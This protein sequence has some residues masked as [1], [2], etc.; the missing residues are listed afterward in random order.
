MS[1]SDLICDK[2]HTLCFSGHRPENLPKARNSQ[3]ILKSYISYEIKEA[4]KDGYTTFIMGGARG[5]DLWAGLAVISEMH[6]CHDIRLVAAL[7]YYTEVSRFTDHERFD[8]GYLLDT[9]SEVFY[10][11]HEY[12][13]DCM[14]R[15]NAFMVDHSSRLIAFVKN[16]QSGTGQTIRLAQKGGI[17]TRVYE[18]DDILTKKKSM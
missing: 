13:Y 14:K 4:I 5:I 3:N 15:R 10:A 7:P 12:R 11:S 2:K 1:D 6:D 9:C 18:I 8:Y 17:E 16:Y